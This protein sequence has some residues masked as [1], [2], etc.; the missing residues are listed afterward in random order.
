MRWGLYEMF[1]AR[2]KFPN[3][4]QPPVFPYL[5]LPRPRLAVTKSQSRGPASLELTKTLHKTI[6]KVIKTPAASIQHCDLTN[7]DPGE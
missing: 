2:S 7:D 4:G 5:P 3:H 6:K 1:M